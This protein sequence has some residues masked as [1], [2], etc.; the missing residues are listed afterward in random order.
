VAC[1]R[2]FSTPSAGSSTDASEASKPPSMN[3][4][5]RRHE[6]VAIDGFVSFDRSWY[7]SKNPTI[8]TTSSSRFVLAF[9]HVT[10]RRSGSSGLILA[11]TSTSFD[12]L[13]I[14]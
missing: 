6:D 13:I 5:A 3:P 14:A 1:L 10:L 2:S 12:T 9:T 4:R 8:S 7:F 11:T